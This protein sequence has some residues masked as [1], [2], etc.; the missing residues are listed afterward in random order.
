MYAIGL[1]ISLLIGIVLGLVGGGGS[2]LTVPLVHYFFGTTIF[3]STTYSL[4]VVAVAA[5]VGVSTRIKKNQV[6]FR[7]GVMFVIP[8][9]ITA[10]L[11]RRYVMAMFPITFSLGDFDLSRDLFITVLLIVVMLFT[12]F[13]TMFSTL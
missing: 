13:R 12:A 2:I 7:G 10:F 5:S 11:I 9:M 6:D 4:F 3:L 1:I 8:S